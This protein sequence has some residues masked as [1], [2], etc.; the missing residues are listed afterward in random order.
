MSGRRPRHGKRVYAESPNVTVYGFE[1][2][3]CL[4]VQLGHVDLTLSRPEFAE[5]AAVIRAAAEQIQLR[6]GSCGKQVH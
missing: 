3:R 6:A 1:D 2:D 4:H 5:I